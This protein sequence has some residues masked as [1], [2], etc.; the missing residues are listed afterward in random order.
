MMTAIHIFF[1][2]RNRGEV[3]VDDRGFLDSAL[4]SYRG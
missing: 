3:V 2:L 1:A 4:T